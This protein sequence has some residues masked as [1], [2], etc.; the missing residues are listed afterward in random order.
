MSRFSGNGLLRQ[1]TIVVVFTYVLL[2]GATLNG[3]ALYE[4]INLSLGLLALAG[5]AWL[6]WTWRRGWASVCS[7][8]TIA[9]TAY[10]AAYAVSAAFSTDPRRSLNALVL[11]VLYAFVWLLVSDLLR[12]GW[13]AESFTRVMT[14]VAS[15]VIG[16]ALWQAVRYESS[17][18]ETSGGGP[19]LPPVILR[20]NPLLTHANM[21]AA[22]LNLFW[23]IVLVKLL[24]ANSW[25]GRAAAGVW[26]L[27]AWGVILLTSSRGAWLGAAAALFVAVGLWWVAREKRRLPS[28]R[29]SAGWLAAGAGVFLLVAIVGV[30]AVRLLQNPTHGSGWSARGLFWQAAWDAFVDHPIVGLGPDTYA[31]AFMQHRSIPPYTLY[32]RAH[33]QVMHVLAENGLVGILAGGA[34][35]A[36]A[37]WAGWRHWQSGSVTERR[38]LAGVA[39]ALVATIV[40]GLFDTP[41][42]VPVNALVISIWAAVL[43]TSPSTVVRRQGA[44]WRRLVPA[45]ILVALIGV[46]AWSQFA[47]RP[48]LDGVTLA[49]VGDWERAAPSLE[50]AVS[51]D[52][53]QVLYN[54]ASGYVHGVLASRGDEAALLVAVRRY[55]TAIEREPGYGL[56]HANLAALYWQKG[57]RPAALAA[58]ARAVAGAPEEATFWLDL[59]LYREE[60]GDLSG[61]GVAYSRTLTLRPVWADAYYWRENDF[62]RS[63]LGEW[64]RVHALQ[65]PQSMAEQAEFALA[66]GRFEDALE[67]YNQALKANPQRASGYAGRAAALLELG[68]E[69]QAAQD[70]RV[71]IFIGGQEPTVVACS[72]W[73]LAQVA[74]NQGDLDAAVLLA[75]QALAAY[76]YQSI[77]GPGTHGSSIY[78]WAIFYRLGLMDDLLPQLVT[79]R[80]TDREIGWMESL[81]S[82]YTEA[83]DLASARRICEEAFLAAPD[84][85]WAAQCPE[86]LDR[87]Q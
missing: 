70:A 22:F 57:E 80:Y 73:L 5:G 82:W 87:E 37:G 72:H 7:P 65:S 58:M 43:V 44:G 78:G 39:G 54:L 13:P 20:P 14:V 62:R 79:I 63:I 30:A 45:S 66:S 18:L 51:R 23:P 28:P 61:A 55:E 50:M 68:R 32:V 74:H 52:P 9:Y 41:P 11:T 33:S 10:L 2:A 27:S 83:G 6:V 12:R 8:M 40:H 38:L 25:P 19:L 3:L 34:L 84:A 31:T 53:G 71:A 76:R 69:E 42:A 77:F 56:N 21:V 85:I 49:N 36:A 75:E 67:L 4:A 1:S 64:R 47:Y 48:Y 60:M 15:I 35:I 81:A 86:T 16:L 59:G 29:L 46:G 17:W 24:S 26:I